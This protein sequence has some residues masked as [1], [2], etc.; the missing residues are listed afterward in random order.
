M[1]R[2]SHRAPSGE[3][4]AADGN[5]PSTDSAAEPGA[6]VDSVQPRPRAGRRLW[7]IVKEILSVAAIALVISFLIKTFLMQAFWIPSGSMEDTLIYGDRVV[8]SKVQAGPLSIDRGDIIVFEDPDN[9]L[10][11]TIEPE[12]GPVR[13]A[14]AETLEF[15]G[16]A[17]TREGNH[18]IKRVIGL[19]GDQVECCDGQGRVSVN[20]QPLTEDYLYPGDEPSAQPFEIT[21]PQDSVWVMGDHRSISGDSRVHDDGTGSTGSVPTER[22]VGQAVALVWPVSRAEWFDRPDTFREVNGAPQ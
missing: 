13:D 2:D 19:G 4:A 15:V 17:P 14:V 12:R 6:V 5:T 1:S 3:D 21:V 18:L 8:V 7:L 9:W 20:G 16:L 11:P 22:I 10:P